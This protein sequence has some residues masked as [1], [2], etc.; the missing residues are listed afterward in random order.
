MIG[1]EYVKLEGNWQRGGKG[2]SQAK[3]EGG[4]R[5]L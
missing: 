3:Q 5:V 1:Y 4:Q 2:T